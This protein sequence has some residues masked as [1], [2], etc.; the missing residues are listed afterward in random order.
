MQHSNVAYNNTKCF[1]SSVIVLVSKKQVFLQL[2]LEL[3][4]G[5]PKGNIFQQDSMARCA[6]SNKPS[7]Y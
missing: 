2:A 4:K 1:G 6:N 5:A 3:E 7:C